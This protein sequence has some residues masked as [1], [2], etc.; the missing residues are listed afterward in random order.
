[1]SNLCRLDRSNSTE[2]LYLIR[3]GRLAH[4]PK[5]CSETGKQKAAPQKK[6]ARDI[7]LSRVLNCADQTRRDTESFKHE[8]SQK[9]APQSV[10][11]ASS[12]T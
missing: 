10:A 12:R 1:M 3:L 5:M 8:M 6:A 7:E 2:M 11:C 9:W 4:E